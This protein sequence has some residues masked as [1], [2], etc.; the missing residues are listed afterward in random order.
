MRPGGH[1]WFEAH[2]GDVAPGQ[3]Y[4]F[5]LD[6]GP[7]R[8][9]PASRWQPD[10]VHGPSAVLDPRFAWSDDGWQGVGLADMVLYELHVGTFTAEGTFDAAAAELPRLCDLGVNALEIM[11][12]AQFPGGRNWGY[13]G[14]YPFAV[15]HSYGGAAGLKRLVDAAHR[16]GVAVLLDVVYNHLGPEGNYFRH[17]GP[18]FTDQYKNP[19]GEAVNF[20]G[21]HSDAVR[22]FFLANA[23]TWQE[24]FRLDGLRLDAAPFIRDGSARH[25][26]AEM[27][28][29]AAALAAQRGRPFH[30]IAESD[31]NDPRYLRPTAAGGLG[32][33]SQWSDDFH[34]ALH[35]H[36]TGERNG[37]YVDHGTLAHVARAYR[38]AYVLAGQFSH[39]RGR[40]YGAPAADRPGEQFVI[41][42]QNHDQ[43]GNRVRGERLPALVD[44]ETLKLVA[45]LLLTAPYVPML[46][47]GEEYGEAAPFPFFT[48]HGDGR[49]IDMVRRGRKHEAADFGWQGDPFDPQDEH[50]FRRAKLDTRQAGAGRGKVLHDW[51]RALLQLRRAHP[52]LRR[53]DRTAAEVVLRE[54][55]GLLCVHRRSAE[56]QA[57]LLFHFG[58]GPSR[59]A[60]PFPPGRWR[61]TLDSADAGWHG[62]GARACG[63][64]HGGEV[65]VAF[66]ARSAVVYV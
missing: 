44:F 29:N 19:W 22:D 13:D 56:G 30:L 57:L 43:V 12:V 46:F 11:P 63:E 10:G 18:Y 32:M 48:S 64:A 17:Y 37:Y 42:A 51:H 54:S 35:A 62:P 31:A 52:A 14:V 41:F 15:Q 3:R 20:D 33:A 45:A 28:D 21:P 50:T 38:D 9:D 25:V 53:P 60:V 23:R 66:A 1:G 2:A 26:L 49:L 16:A 65:E 36:L 34:H 59:A 47:M 40:R 55:D 4:L 58:P 6:D 5:R 24:E 39:Y 61:K 7:D 8:P 27:A